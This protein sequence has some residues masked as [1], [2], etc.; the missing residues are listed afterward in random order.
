MATVLKQL[1]QAAI[2]TTFSTIYT[3]PASTTTIIKELAI[4]NTTSSAITVNVCAVPSGG[5]AGTGNAL[6]YG[7]SISA[8]LPAFFG[9][10]NTVLPTGVTLQVSASATG[11][12]ITASGVEVS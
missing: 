8:N 4:C 2:G 6:I 11:L 7:Y 10:M 9:G 3:V 12:T 5:T 1:G